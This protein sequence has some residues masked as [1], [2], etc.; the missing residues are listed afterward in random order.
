MISSYI[1][2][3]LEF[4]KEFL[5]GELEVELIPQVP[6]ISI[7]LTNR[8]GLIKVIC[9]EIELS[10]WSKGTLAEKIRCGGAGIPA[11]YT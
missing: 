5:N 3:N 2:G 8:Q 10:F 11:F 6:V 1:G 7:A 9:F 4:E